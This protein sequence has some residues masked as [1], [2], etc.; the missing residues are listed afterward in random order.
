[1]LTLPARWSKQ[2]IAVASAPIVALALA[3]VLLQEGAVPAPRMF[4]SIPLPFL[5]ESSS[6]QGSLTLFGKRNGIDVYEVNFNHAEPFEHL[7][8]DRIYLAHIPSDPTVSDVPMDLALTLTGTGGHLVDYYG[9]RYS[10]AAATME[11]RD[12]AAIRFK[13]RFPGQFFASNTARARDALNGSMLAAFETAYGVKFMPTDGTLGSVRLDPAGALYVLVVNDGGGADLAVRGVTGCGN[14]IVEAAEQCDDANGINGDECTNTCTLGFPIP[15]DQGATGTGAALSIVQEEG[16]NGNASAASSDISLVRFTATATDLF[17]LRKL[18]FRAETGSLTALRH[19][20]IFVDADGDGLTETAVSPEVAPIGGFVTFDEPLNWSG[21][22]VRRTPTIFE[23][24]ADVP[25]TV[26]GVQ[27]IRVIFSTGTSD[28]IGGK[29]IEGTFPLVGIRTNG[30]AC[31]SPIC[32]MFVTTKAS[33]LW[34]IGTLSDCGNGVID[35][36]EECDYSVA[37]MADDCDNACR[38][39]TPT[40]DF[41]NGP[42]ILCGDGYIDP[43]EECDDGSTQSGDGCSDVCAVEQGFLC[44]GAPSQCTPPLPSLCGNGQLNADEECDDGNQSN[45]D[46]C[47]TSCQLTTPTPSL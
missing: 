22:L 4:G 12:I 14:R 11:R 42:S 30:G 13:D 3:F 26:I 32:Q 6:L 20:Q 36:G 31:L 39:S 33:I 19:Y 28:F 35:L 29:R 18:A 10:D 5:S 16:F 43:N 46:E 15:F 21:A 38:L 27:K 9:Y 47:D 45:T 41:G 1:M 2:T 17:Q 34:T 24:K 37:G 8:V 23:L 44:T 7:S 40:P 25:E